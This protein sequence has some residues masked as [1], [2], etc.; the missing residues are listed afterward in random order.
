MEQYV[1]N[2]EQNVIQY[3]EF[4]TSLARDQ[5]LLFRWWTS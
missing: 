2:N 3:L 1:L 4:S 5:N